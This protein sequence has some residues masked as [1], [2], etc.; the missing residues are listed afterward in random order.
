M[1]NPFNNLKLN[2][3]YAIALVLSAVVFLYS[4]AFDVKIL[5]NNTVAA[6]SLGTFFIFLS[7]Y[8]KV[9]KVINEPVKG[10]IKTSTKLIKGTAYKVLFCIGLCLVIIG[11]YPIIKTL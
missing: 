10:G 3:W 1:D 9:R 6:L 7:N 4:L 11:I 2:R 8:A 5:D